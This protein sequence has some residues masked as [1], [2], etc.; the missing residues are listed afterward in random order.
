MKG[1]RRTGY[2]RPYRPPFID[3]PGH[4][5]ESTCAHFGCMKDA[6]TKYR[7]GVPLCNRHMLSLMTELREIEK[8]AVSEFVAA[9]PRATKLA[10]GVAPAHEPLVY[11]VRFRDRI[12]IGTSTNIQARLRSIPHEALLGTEPGGIDVERR[13]HRQFA[14]ERTNGEWFTATSRILQHIESIAGLAK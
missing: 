11:Y 4:S 5:L 8:A 2:Q 10:E 1:T 3:R 13:R 12:K 9:N 6:Q 14:D 7:I